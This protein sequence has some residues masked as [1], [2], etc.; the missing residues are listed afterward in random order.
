[1]STLPRRD[2]TLPT[3]D[4]EARLRLL[5]GQHA[6]EA[7]Q[8]GRISV[9]GFDR[10]KERFGPAWERLA[11]RADRL[12]R[13]VIERHLMPGDIFAA[14]QDASYVIVFASLDP[15]P[16]KMKCLMIADAIMK[17]LFGE[18]GGDLISIR[19]A[20]A[21]LEP[22]S[23]GVAG[24]TPDR[25]R[26]I[27][28]TATGRAGADTP[29]ITPAKP[30]PT[31]KDPLSRLRFAYR[32]MWDS[33]LGALSAYLCVGLLPSS[34]DGDVYRDAESVLAG[35]PE[36][37]A[38]LDF[39]MLARAAEDF[40][41]ICRDGFK[42]LII[43]NVHFESIAAGARRRRYLE[44]LAQSIPAAAVN[45]LVVEIADVPDGVLQSRMHELVAPLRPHCRGVS[46][47]VRLDSV[48]FVGLGGKQVHAVGCSIGTNET[49]EVTIIQHMGRF[50][51][52][53]EKCALPCFIHGIR[54]LSLTGAALGAGF[55]YVDGSAVAPPVD[56]PDRVS[57]FNLRD[58]YRTIASG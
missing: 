36:R 4:F 6:E 35:D 34:P 31:Q 3:T 13:N 17:V 52:E 27:T 55:R 45:L 5:V 32:P 44:A 39:A 54:S 56:R 30:E 18:D 53:A 22:G 29:E 15:E 33:T 49:S 23:D 11:D 20:V 58:I 40:A 16:A 47:R 37:M 57:V 51:R 12:A 41:R 1:M 9:I 46:A 19:S 26:A 42:V 48:N 43:L 21:Q 28:P 24:L 7:L 2:K 10:V 38:L 14:W 25:F 8:A 50:A